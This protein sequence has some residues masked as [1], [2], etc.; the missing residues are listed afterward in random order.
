MSTDAVDDLQTG[1]DSLAGLV[2]GSLTLSQVLAEVAASAVRAIPGAEGASV[3]VLR[4]ETQDH[5]VAERVASAPFVAE[6]EDIQ[7]VRLREGPSITAV[8]QRRPVRSGSLGG[9]KQ[10]WPRF[11]PKVGRLGVHSALAVPLLLPDQVVGAICVYAHGKDAFDDD[12]AR[13][14]E[15]LAKPAA[16]AVHNAW[17]L[18][19]ALALTDH[20]KA[21]LATRPV[22]DQA[23]GIIRS[24]TGCTAEDA[25][26]KLIALSQSA[27]RK[28]ADV[29]GQIVDEAVR[30]AR[31]ARAGKPGTDAGV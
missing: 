12:A 19:E 8:R 15:L 28:L 3:A 18:A 23:I 5:R 30:R 4:P 13:F 29:A 10:T 26:A 31:A 17:V 2:A 9:E 21:A 16:V 14:G 22:I 6:I 7:H 11:G 25:F 27:Q 20:L 1:L 24:R